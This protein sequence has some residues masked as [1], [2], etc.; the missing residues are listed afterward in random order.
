MEIINIVMS[1][2]YFG[3]NGMPYTHTATRSLN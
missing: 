3:H 2:H 1:C